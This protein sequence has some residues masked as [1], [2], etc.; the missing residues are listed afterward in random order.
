AAWVWG[1]VAVNAPDGSIWVAEGRHP[2][3][4]G[5]KPQV[6]I[7]DSSGNQIKNILVDG[8]PMSIAVDDQ[9]GCSWI[10]TTEGVLK[11]DLE[12]HVL[13]RFPLRAYSVGVEPDTG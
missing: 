3:I 4:S 6:L 1:A 7:L 9:H 10:T 13:S 2:Q 11:S 12:G 8:Q 5:S